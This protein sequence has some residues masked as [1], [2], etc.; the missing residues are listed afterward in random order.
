[1][2]GAGADVFSHSQGADL[3]PI[4]SQ[5][6]EP[7]PACGARAK[8]WIRSQCVCNSARDYVNSYLSQEL[9]FTYPLVR[10]SR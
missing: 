3:E 7:E 4:W 9:I 2:C 5:C 6:E 1:M 8:L 10:R